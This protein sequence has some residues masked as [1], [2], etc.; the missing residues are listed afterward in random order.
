M[1]GGGGR[2]EG[3]GEREGGGGS[4]TCT[5]QG[6]EDLCAVGSTNAPRASAKWVG[7]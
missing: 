7:A 1:E 6:G 2:M 5:G 3:E 4:Q